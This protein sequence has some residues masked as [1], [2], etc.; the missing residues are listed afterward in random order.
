MAIIEVEVRG[1]LSKSEFDGVEKFLKKNC[2]SYIRDN[3]DSTFFLIPEGT[4]KVSVHSSQNK[5]RITHKIKDLEDNIFATSKTEFDIPIEDA[6]KAIA[7]F[8]KIGHVK[9]L[10]IKHE[11]EIFEYKAVSI[12]LKISEDLGTHF[13]IKCVV[14]KKDEIPDAMNRIDSVCEE[15]NIKYMTEQESNQFFKQVEK[16]YK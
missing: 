1:L 6:E 10:K 13:E 14:H 3:K 7:M 11:S 9:T 4:L 16:D 2:E 12:H 8:K 15:L 5:A